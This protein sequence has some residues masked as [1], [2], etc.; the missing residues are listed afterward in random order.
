MES[1][2]CQQV[3][4]TPD[5][6]AV[7]DGSRTLTY[8]ELLVEADRLA[9]A[10][11][12]R[13]LGPEEPVCIFTG[14]GAGQVIA[15]VAVLRAG[16]TSVPIDQSTPKLRVID[17]LEDIGAKHVITDQGEDF[18]ATGFNIIPLTPRAGN[19]TNGH[20]VLSRS[21]NL[22]TKEN[23]NYRSHILFTSGS[24]GKPKAVQI[25]G[26]GIIHVATR[27]PMTPLEATDR[28]TQINSPGFD[29]SLFEI[30]ASLLCGA[31][32]VVV[33]RDVA[34]DPFALRGFIREKGVTVL[35]MTTSL[36]GITAFACP[37]AFQGVQHLLTAGEAANAAAMRQVL[38]QQ[39]HG[40]GPENLWNCYGP[41]EA[42][43][44]ATAHLVRLEDTDTG[45][46]PIGRPAGESLIYLL[47]E[48]LTPGQEGEICIGGPGVSL[49]YINRPAENEQ[50]F[51]DVKAA[52]LGHGEG[53]VSRTVRLFRTGDMARWQRRGETDLLEFIGRV[54]TQVK[55]GGFRVEL[56]EI[57]QT[58]VSSGWLKAAV[59]L[60]L[61]PGGAEGGEP[62]LVAFVI[63]SIAD[64]IRQDNVLSYAKE[65]LPSYM[66]PHSVIFR[67]DLPLTANGKVDR[68]ALAESY[69]QS[70]PIANGVTNGTT[71]DHDKGA[72]TAI[73]KNIWTEL[74]NRANFD[75]NDDFFLLGASS[76]QAA[77]LIGKIF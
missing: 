8:M 34:T 16:G 52:K 74:L 4:S 63:P 14:I 17:M 51:L 13:Q 56:G 33:P 15:Q 41:T 19:M 64:Q 5:A 47:D 68:K 38:L 59:V 42:T 30:W 72:M 3:N 2:L 60:Q 75:A 24:T 25:P 35:F 48:T 26:R 23:E 11:R 7:T 18:Q 28:V 20:R 21:V 61:R 70:Q 73:V 66:I 67:T 36:F 69:Q 29:L 6:L 53:R 12:Q 10:L 62:V 37:T 44:F 9:D 40:R 76:M 43:V 71:H 39:P 50:H 46:I 65:R 22:R 45:N 27:T 49:G 57:E 32:I 55:Q 1:I 58:L 31:S 54:D 77:A